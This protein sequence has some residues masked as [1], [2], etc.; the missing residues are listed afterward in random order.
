MFKVRLFS[1]YSSSE[2]IRNSS[3]IIKPLFGENLEF[4]MTII[5]RSNRILSNSGTSKIQLR[6]SNLTARVW[7]DKFRREKGHPRIRKTSKKYYKNYKI[8]LHHLQKRKTSIKTDNP[9]GF[10][11]K[12]QNLHPSQNRSMLAISPLISP[13]SLSIPSSIRKKIKI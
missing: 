2:M 10:K 3:I 11:L 12:F 1:I 8:A 5:T 4:F 9:I 13:K 6:V 7:K